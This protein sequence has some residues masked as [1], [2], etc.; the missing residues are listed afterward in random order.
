MIE[1]LKGWVLNITTIVMLIV[2]F[3]L[4]VPTGKIKKF[5]SLI[6]GVILIITIVNP[7]VKLFGK[8]IDLKEFQISESNF[9][10]K[11]E[12]NQN[13]EILKEEQQKQ[14]VEVYRGKIISQLE[15]A[16]KG[17]KGMEE[18][19]ADVIIN[20][21]YKSDKFGEIKRIY[22]KLKLSNA[23]SQ[24][25]PITKIN[26]VKIGNSEEPGQMENEP[27]SELSDDMRNDITEKVSNLFDVQNENIVISLEK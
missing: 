16:I 4:L 18:V 19:T 21:D 27:G 23:D 11:R 1:F 9:L 3:E 15:N 5:I 17:V 20:E 6:S 8:S 12:I 26:K 7:F 25:K 2:L 10:D 14:I 24:I 22:L 13:S